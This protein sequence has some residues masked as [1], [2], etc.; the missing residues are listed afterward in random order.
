MVE[1]RSSV[2]IDVAYEGRGNA[3]LARLLD[4]MTRYRTKRNAVDFVY[5]SVSEADDKHEE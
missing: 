5:R 1:D 3:V 4:E 2:P